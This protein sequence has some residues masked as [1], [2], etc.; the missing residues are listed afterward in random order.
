M[1]Q[2]YV[3]EMVADWTGAGLAQGH[4]DDVVPWYQANKDKMVLHPAT[5]REVETLI[6]VTD[7]SG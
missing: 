2:D 7:G 4:G 1:P 3:R 5:R 6:G